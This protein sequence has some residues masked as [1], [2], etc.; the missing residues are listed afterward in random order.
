MMTLA[1]VG[2]GGS[3]LHPGCFP[4]RTERELMSALDAGFERGA[5]LI[6]LAPSY[7]G[8]GSERLVGRWLADR[9]TREEVT[10]VTKL[11]PANPGQGHEPVSARVD[12][13]L[14]RLRTD[15]LDIVLLHSWGEPA[16]VRDAVLGELG[17]LADSGKIAVVGMSAMDSDPDE[18]VPLVTSGRLPCVSLSYNVFDRS[19]AE[20]LL[21]CCSDRGVTVLGRAPF[22]HGAL[23]GFFR[24]HPELPPGDDRSEAFPPAVRALVAPR[25]EAFEALARAERV[26]APEL[27]L[28]FVAM[29]TRIDTIV[30][31]M[32]TAT[33]IRQNIQAIV[34][35]KSLSPAAITR[36]R[37]LDWPDR[38]GMRERG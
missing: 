2:I 19:R 30:V 5:T 21:S 26:S 4:A 24:S 29:E 20:G 18:L 31:G 34:R 22:L 8:G 28:G 10:L 15:H 3:G 32:R 1:R 27:A 12:A 35:P 17:Q 37:A 33:E 25:V 23:V 36:L 13:S 6:D 38:F 7:G 16:E 11:A 14:R 9:G